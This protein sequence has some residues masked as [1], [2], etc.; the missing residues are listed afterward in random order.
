MKIALTGSNGYIGKTFIKIHHDLD[1]VKL[2]YN[3]EKNE[4]VLNESKNSKNMEK[5][6]N[7]IESLIHL[8]SFMPKN[9]NQAQDKFLSAKNMESMKKLLAF[10]FSNLKHIIY[11]SSIDVY[12][13]STKVTEETKPNPR[14]EYAK[15]KL[16]CEEIIEVYARDRKISSSI[17]RLGTVYGPGDSIFKKAIPVMMRSCIENKQIT[18]KGNGSVRRNFLYVEDAAKLIGEVALTS[19]QIRLINLVGLHSTSISELAYAISML[20][21]ENGVKIQEDEK[22]IPSLDHKFDTA[23]LVY[24]FPN[25]RFT[26]IMVGLKRELEH[27][28]SLMS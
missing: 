3:L 25:F 22:N 20:F 10:E 5:E 17:L 23:F 7:S 26:P 11:I 18:I 15:S 21:P 27:L 12:D 1:L 2:S 6:I 4:F 19:K 14:T 16:V 24:N 9:A 13:F 8:G 28:K